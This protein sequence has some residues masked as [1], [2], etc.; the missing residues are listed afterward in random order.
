MTR[1]GKLRVL[2]VTSRDTG[3][4]VIPKGW[5]M[6][7][8]T[9]AAAAAVEALQEAGVS[10]RIEATPV[11][12]YRYEKPDIAPGT[13]LTVAVYTLW[14]E[15]QGRRWL[16]RNARRRRWF[17]APS[18]AKL[19]AEPDLAELIGRLS[20]DASIATPRPRL[21]TKVTR[22]RRPASVI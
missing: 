20:E 1:R 18:A 9:D 10:G 21:R 15:Q 7:G 11:G 14:V 17:N 5:P 19:V 3:R 2:L 22:V 13:L 4:W 16:E 6:D 12:S 8:L